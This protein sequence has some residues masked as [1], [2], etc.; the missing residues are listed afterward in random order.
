MKRLFFIVNPISGSGNGARRFEAV[1]LILEEKGVDYGFALTQYPGHAISL[2]KEALAAGEA[3]IVSVGGDGT[4]REVASV[5]A[6]VPGAVLGVLPFGTGNDFARGMGLP[7]DEARLT[8]IL[9]GDAV[10]T[11]DAGDADGEFFINVAGFGFDVDVVRYTE[12]YKKKLNGMLPYMLGIF[13]SLLH[14]AKSRVHVETDAGEEFD[15]TAILFSACNGNR[16]AGGIRLAPLADPCDGLLDICILKRV[17]RLRFLYLLPFYIKGK[18]LRFEKE[19]LYFK[20]KS[21]TASTEESAP[22]DLDGEIAG[23][24]PVTFRIVPGA[25]RLLVAS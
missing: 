7:D 1:R 23:K 2:A 4:L 22:L 11:V 14:L 5:L 8:D 25:L 12:R 6:G 3:R 15:I 17:N 9:L 24:T 20:A 21:V 10:R 19:F 18:H 13:Q 16:F